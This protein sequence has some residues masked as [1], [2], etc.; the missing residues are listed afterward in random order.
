[1]MADP[2][3]GAGLADCTTIL[4]HPNHVLDGI[5]GTRTASCHEYRQPAEGHR[6]GPAGI[7]GNPHPVQILPPVGS[8][9]I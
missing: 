3:M 2:D 1:M 5:Q 9:P 7:T 4:I 8:M 6:A